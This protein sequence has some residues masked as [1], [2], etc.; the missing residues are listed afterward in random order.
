MGEIIKERRDRRNK[1]EGREREEREIL[2]NMAEGPECS[3]S[4]PE[5]SFQWWRG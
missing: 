2:A 1:G 4:C 3:K 5:G